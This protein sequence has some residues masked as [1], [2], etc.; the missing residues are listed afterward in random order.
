MEIVIKHTIPADVEEV[1]HGKWLDD[2]ICAS[3]L[4]YYPWKCSVCG[5]EERVF[6]WD[7]T[8]NYCANCEAKMDKE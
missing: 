6:P 5:Y 4:G 3:K 2:N 7:N 8:H 1:K